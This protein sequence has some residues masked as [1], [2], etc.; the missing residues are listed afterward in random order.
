[1]KKATWYKSKG[2]KKDCKSVLFVQPTKDSLLKRK[3]EDVISKSKCNVKGI[4]RAGV[5][6]S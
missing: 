6:I 2:S 1:M 3:Y 5:N 4:K